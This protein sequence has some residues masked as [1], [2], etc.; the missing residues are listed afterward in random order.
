MAEI[1]IGARA[2]VAQGAWRR[3][4]SA[5]RQLRRWPAFSIV[6]LTLLIVGTVGAPWIAPY[7]ASEGSTKDGNLPPVF[8]GG[9]RAHILGTDAL[10]RDMFSRILYGG[11]VSL[12]VAAVVL[13][14]A[15]TVGTTLGLLSGYLG[16][17]VD[18]L[19]M[20]VVDAKNSIPL[21]L[22]ALLVAVAFGSTLTI[23]LILLSLWLWSGY[24]RQVRGEVLRLRE[25]DYVK[26]ARV[27]GASTPR[28][29]FRHLL[30][31]VFDTVMVL[32]THQ[33]GSVILTEAGLSF[34]GAGIPPPTPAWGSM[35]NQGLL[36]LRDAWWVSI[37][38]GLAIGLT[39]MAFT[40]L[41]DWLRDRLDPQLRQLM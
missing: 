5:A 8:A 38:P 14:V 2:G 24:A 23:L 17:W 35:V 6:V 9:A 31:G 4:R 13:V 41:G 30:P 33:V 26:L 39:V 25:M 34:L 20:R 22:V 11:R 21:I 29:L 36:Y 40:F 18:E 16:G 1:A 3:V 12:M 10:G 15:G 28:I 37:V 27:A 19:I 32:A 7:S